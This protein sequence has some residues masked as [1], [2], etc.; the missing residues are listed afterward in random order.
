MMIKAAVDVPNP[1]SPRANETD[2]VCPQTAVCLTAQP[3]RMGDTAM[4][5]R[6]QIQTRSSL[7]DQLEALPEGLTGEILKGD[8]PR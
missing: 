3:P 5:A 7:Y 1:L 4:Q 2:W 8:G 6:R